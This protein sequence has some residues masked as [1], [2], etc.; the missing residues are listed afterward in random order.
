[1]PETG[2]KD[3]PSGAVPAMENSTLLWNF[4]IYVSERICLRTG[5][6]VKVP[7]QASLAQDARVKFC[8]SICV[9]VYVYVCAYVCMYNLCVCA[10]ECMYACEC[11][12]ICLCACVHIHL[13][14]Y[15]CG[16]LCMCLCICVYICIN[17][18][19]PVCICVHEYVHVCVCDGVP[20]NVSMFVVTIPSSRPL[21]NN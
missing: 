18:Y 3:R 17:T 5:Q 4:P 7:S 8:V 20:M 10:H 16:Y 12:N 13:C 6:G 9:S 21:R 15:E 2:D 14:V 1:M 11:P 19:M